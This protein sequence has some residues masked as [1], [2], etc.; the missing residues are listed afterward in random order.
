M[1][2]D[3]MTAFGA[4]DMLMRHDV[5]VVPVRAARHGNA[6]YLARSGELTEIAVDCTHCDGGHLLTG[7]T[8]NFVCGEMPGTADDG[9]NNL[10]L[11]S[12]KITSEL[13]IGIVPVFR[14]AQHNRFVNRK[15]I[16]FRKILLSGDLVKM[17]FEKSVRGLI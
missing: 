1:K 14:I 9:E 11:L 17:S 6:P 4:G 3:Y 15:F 8:E 16:F 5:A 10:F 12:D 7:E 2:I 13:G